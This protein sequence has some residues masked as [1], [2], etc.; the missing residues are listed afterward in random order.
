MCLFVEEIKGSMISKITAGCEQLR[1]ALA[2]LSTDATSVEGFVSTWEATFKE[3]GIFNREFPDERVPGEEMS[4]YLRELL[5]LL[6][7]VDSARRNPLKENL[8]AATR[9]LAEANELASETLEVLTCCADWRRGPSSALV[10]ALEEHGQLVLSLKGL[11]A[12][13]GDSAAAADIIRK[14][15]A[16]VSAAADK[17]AKLEKSDQKDMPI[18]LAEHVVGLVERLRKTGRRPQGA[19]DLLELEGAAKKSLAAANAAAEKLV[20]GKA[21]TNV[22]SRKGRRQGPKASKAWQQ[23]VKA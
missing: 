8:T 6:R 1:R 15:E 22:A 10:A 17:V 3:V 23:A 21:G 19:Q 18:A 11:R 12:R 5:P 7:Q 13:F 20:N 4:W 14:A 16:A 2:E 9:Q